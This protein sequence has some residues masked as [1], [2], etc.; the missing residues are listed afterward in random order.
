MALS[1]AA[2]NGEVE[3]PDA[4]L[5][6]TRVERS[7]SGDSHSG[8]RATRAHTLSRARGAKQEA[9]HGPLQRLLGNTWSASTERLWVGADLCNSKWSE[10]IPQPPKLFVDRPKLRVPVRRHEAFDGTNARYCS[11][12]SSL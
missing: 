9:S 3:G 2:S 6:R 8:R 7:S 1:T 4:A 11:D 5:G 10:K 12:P